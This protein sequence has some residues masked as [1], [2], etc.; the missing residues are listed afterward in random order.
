[1]TGRNAKGQGN[2]DKDKL[3]NRRE[4]RSGITNKSYTPTTFMMTKII[5]FHFSKEPESMTSDLA[6]LDEN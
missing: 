5:L 2:V 1:M 4:K 6:D 3:N